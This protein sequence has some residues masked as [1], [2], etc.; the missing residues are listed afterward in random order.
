VRNEFQ[1]AMRL[2]RGRDPQQAE[3]GFQHLR[4]M[5]ADHVDDLIEEFRRERD[6]GVRCWLLELIG[7]ARSDRAF[8]VLAEELH[9]DDEALRGWAV[10]GLQTLDTVQARRLLWQWRQNR[11]GEAAEADGP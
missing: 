8:L 4:G 1:Q 9:G 2:M 10:R 6:H 11:P 5:A 7:A 3:D